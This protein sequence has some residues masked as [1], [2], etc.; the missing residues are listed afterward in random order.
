LRRFWNRLRG[1]FFGR[2]QEKE[3]T[4]EMD[5]HIAMQA[6]DNLRAGM[7]PE[8]ARR[9]A[10]LKFGAV[11][12]S[13]ESY[14]DQRGLP[15]LDLLRQDL[16]YAIRQLRKTPGFTVCVVLNRALGIG[17]NT[18]I[19]SVMNRAMLRFLPVHDPKQLVY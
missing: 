1:A 4:R 16:R 13:K 9:A 6:E 2:R 7:T 10:V 17:A 3:M 15:Q 14:R 11:E 18:E 19:F 12:S 5:T 8:E